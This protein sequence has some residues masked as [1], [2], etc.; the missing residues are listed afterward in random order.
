[1]RAAVVAVFVVGAL[2]LLASNAARGELDL[3]VG[4][5][6]GPV[7]LLKL[8]PTGNG[9]V[10]STAITD[11]SGVAVSP[12]GQ[13]FAASYTV[14]MDPNTV[15]QFSMSGQ[16][17]GAFASGLQG[18]DG[19][20]FDQSGNLYVSS[21]H[22][23]AVRRVSSCDRAGSRRFR[24]FISGPGGLASRSRPATSMSPV[25][26][27]ASWRSFH[28][29][30][31]TWASSR[32]PDSRAQRDWRSTRLATSTSPIQTVPR[33]TSSPRLGPILASSRAACP[34]PMAWHSIRREI[35]T[36]PTSAT[37]R[38]RKSHRP[39]QTLARSRAA[40]ATP[41]SSLSDRRPRCPSP[42]RSRFWGLAVSR[43]SD[44]G[45]W[46]V[47]R[48]EVVQVDRRA[49]LCREGVVQ[50]QSRKM[51]HLITSRDRV[52]KAK[53]SLEASPA[54][55]AEAL[56]LVLFSMLLSAVC[57]GDRRDYRCSLE[58]QV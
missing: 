13:V 24:D 33:S 56:S 5:A 10:F 55:S 16:D 6:T 34:A 41:R 1:M 15:H 9:T 46:L 21:F 7:G 12:F 22:G 25:S 26:P 53:A 29:L 45:E 27:A 11:T 58:G 51:N 14:G 20:A 40:S 54:I 17:L 50:I 4:Q 52:M 47:D 19:I 8:D 43:S 57:R 35:F 23:D 44:G 42:P 39:E 3:F 38:S 31:P 49:A 18:P 48:N 30:G 32:R 2:T 28:R 37:G 36:W